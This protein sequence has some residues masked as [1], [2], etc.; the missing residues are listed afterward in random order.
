[1]GP[2]PH[3]AAWSA[4]RE[5]ASDG[6]LIWTSGLQD[7]VSGLLFVVIYCCSHRKPIQPL[8]GWELFRLGEMRILEPRSIRSHSGPQGRTEAQEQA[9]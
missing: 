3:P 2:P 1:M 6:T 9:D 5:Q 4:F 8:S 7:C